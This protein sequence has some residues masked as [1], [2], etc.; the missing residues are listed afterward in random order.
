MFQTPRI[1]NPDSRIHQA[2]YSMMQT[3]ATANHECS[4]IETGIERAM[5]IEN[6]CRTSPSQAPS[7]RRFYVDLSADLEK[8]LLKKAKHYLKLNKQKKI[9]PELTI[10]NFQQRVYLLAVSWSNIT[11][12]GRSHGLADREC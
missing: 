7:D 12:G 4:S 5:N 1:A 11:Y 6:E 8:R 10:E 3:P 2:T 9:Q